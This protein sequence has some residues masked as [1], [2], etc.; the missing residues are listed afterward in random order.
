MENN[1]SNETATV[2]ADAAVN[3]EK[4]VKKS[5]RTMIL[6]G[7]IAL[8]LIAVA[9]LVLWNNGTFNEA[10]GRV[11]Y[12]TRDANA[13]MLALS[14]QENLPPDWDNVTFVE[15][16]PEE[17]Q[18]RVGDGF[19]QIP[20]LGADGVTQQFVWVADTVTANAFGGDAHFA[21]QVIEEQFTVTDVALNNTEV[22]LYEGDN[23]RL[24]AN[25]SPNQA[26]DKRVS[27]SSSDPAVA[28]VDSNGA[29][30]AVHYGTAVI[31]AVC[32]NGIKAEAA[33]TV[34][35]LPTSVSLD[36]NSADIY[37]GEAFS[38]TA[39][40]APQAAKDAALTW[41][42]SDESVATVNGGKVNGVG[43]G[44]AKITVS[45]S[46]GK[47]DTCTVNVTVAPESI[48]LDKESLA[49]EADD[50]ATLQA[51]VLPDNATDKTV[52]WQSSDTGVAT[53][54]NGTVTAISGGSCTV[55]ATASNGIS[56]ECH[57]TVKNKMVK[58]EIIK[59]GYKYKGNGSFGLTVT[60]N[61]STQSVDFIDCHGNLVSTKEQSGITAENK[62]WSFSFSNPGYDIYKFSFKACNSLGTA[63]KGITID[64]S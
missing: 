36:K 4:P 41:A 17:A 30:N 50:K 15:I 46:N 34:L 57:V 60:T 53:V 6:Y 20:V 62:T 64:V 33:V 52:S 13:Q 49:M 63:S 16:D 7:V 31:T 24:T 21:E 10:L 47:S 23:A 59:I 26:F 25:V 3:T 51:T 40:I 5:K 11:V 54:D 39:S 58:P 18:S 27:W 35:A 22:S 32:E 29:V 44:T 14:L 37:A 28:A 55:T 61:G 19:V 43:Y 45:T 56:A 12:Y 38:L 8:L 9:V 2:A 48:T 1:L 42:T